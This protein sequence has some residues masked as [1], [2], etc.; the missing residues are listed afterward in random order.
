MERSRGVSVPSPALA[1]R[2]AEAE[3]RA[4]GGEEGDVM[5]SAGAQGRSGRV[6]SQRANSRRK[7]P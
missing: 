2:G 4:G 5:G 1:E 6:A 3:T 7:T